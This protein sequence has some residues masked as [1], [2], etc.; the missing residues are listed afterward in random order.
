MNK[1]FE[2]VASEIVV[3]MIQAKLIT[4]ADSGKTWSTEVYAEEV[5]QAFRTVY[6]AV[7]NE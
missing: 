1:S 6:A 3:A 7:A 2:E 4:P 5:A